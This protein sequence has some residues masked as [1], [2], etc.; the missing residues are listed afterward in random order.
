MLYAHESV[1]SHVSTII[2]VAATNTQV[3]MVVLASLTAF[4]ITVF[5]VRRQT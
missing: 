4:I 1:N 2:Q 5:Q 3:Y